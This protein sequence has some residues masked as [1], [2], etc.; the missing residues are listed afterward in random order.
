MKSNLLLSPENTLKEALKKINKNRLKTAVVID[1]RNNLL[2]L[3]NDGIIRRAL[4]KNAKLNEKIK[5]YF[6]RE[7]KYILFIRTSLILLKTINL[8]KKDLNLV[9]VVDNK[10]KVVDFLHKNKVNSVLRKRLNIPLIIMC[11]GM[12]L[13]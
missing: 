3:I 11:G 10:F 2:G 5:R 13:E 9:P 6:T 8:I 4:I 12:V 7:R 1:N